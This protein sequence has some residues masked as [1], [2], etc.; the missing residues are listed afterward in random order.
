MASPYTKSKGRICRV[1]CRYR[2][3]P[4][5]LKD[6]I[7]IALK[8]VPQVGKAQGAAL[9]VHT[10]DQ[11]TYKNFQTWFDWL[12]GTKAD[13]EVRKAQYISPNMKPPGLRLRSW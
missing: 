6:L 3:Q 7:I 13:G 5:L 11:V 2:T 12:S 10:A 8:I 4:D 9:F 1:T